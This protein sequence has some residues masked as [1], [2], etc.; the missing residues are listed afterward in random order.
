MMSFTLHSDDN[1][2]NQQRLTA[3][4]RKIHDQFDMGFHDLPRLLR[5]ALR[6]PRLVD[7][8]RFTLPDKEEWV[9]VVTAARRTTRRALAGQRRMMWQLT[10]PP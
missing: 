6:R 8:L 10:H 4:D 3:F 1:I 5:P 7:A 2:V 9:Q